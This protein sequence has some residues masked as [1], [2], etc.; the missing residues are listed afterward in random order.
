M[1]Q[2]SYFTDNLK[3]L[4]GRLDGDTSPRAKELIDKGR[5]LLGTLNGWSFHRPTEEARAATVRELLE[6]N[7]G[8]L[9]YLLGKAAHAR[10]SIRPVFKPP[11]ARVEKKR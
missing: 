2:P 4:L 10:S 3:E 11:T 8:T 5:V 6:F 7:R 1:T 9:D